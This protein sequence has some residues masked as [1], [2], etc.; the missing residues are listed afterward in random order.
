[1][2]FEDF[3]CEIFEDF[4]GQIFRLWGKSHEDFGVRFA[5]KRK[6]SDEEQERGISVMFEDFLSKKQKKCTVQ[7]HTVQK[8]ISLSNTTV[9]SYKND[10][11]TFLSF[12]C[13]WHTLLS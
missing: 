10:E 3:W 12:L 2:M 5:E 1:V 4:M 9:M 11:D 13:F 6:P 7:T 8:Q